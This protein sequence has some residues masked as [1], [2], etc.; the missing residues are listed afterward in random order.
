MRPATDPFA[1]LTLPIATPR[2]ILRLPTSRDVP[3]L[4]RSFRDGRTAR[5]VG[6][7][8]HSTEEMRDPIKMVR[9]TRE[10]F[11]KAT[12]LSLSTI[13]RSDGHCVGR[14]GLRGLDWKWRTVESLSYWVDSRFWNRGYATE[15]SWFL[16]RAAFSQLGMRRI[17]S[18]ALAPN[19]AS[20]RVL[21]KL[22]FVR[23]GRQRQAVRV[24]GRPMD[25]VLY[26]LLRGE[27]VPWASLA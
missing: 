7:P 6:A 15:A 16:C 14:V 26:G 25:M 5:A 27:L 8:L 24:R 3:D 17:A 12:D 20:L 4:E 9:R 1:R 22:G 23:E 11:L 19:L 13:Q 18:S 10:E 21:R 2:L